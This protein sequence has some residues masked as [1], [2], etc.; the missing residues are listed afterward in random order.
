MADKTNQRKAYKFLIEKEAKG[1]TFTNEEIDAAANWSGDTFKSYR[2]KLLKGLIHK[3]ENG[4]F[5]VKGLLGVTENEFI[6]HLSQTGILRP[7]SRQLHDLLNDTDSYNLTEIINLGNVDI[8]K[9]LLE[10]VLNVDD[11]GKIIE[12]LNV[13]FENAKGS[14]REKLLYSLK[15]QN[16]T[17]TDFDIISGRKEGLELFKKNLWEESKWIE[18]DWQKF[19]ETNTW[20]FGYG[21]DY[22]FL[23]ILQ[24][25]A[26]VSE[27]TVGGEEVV[28]VDFLVGDKNFTTLIE[29]KKPNTPIFDNLK[30]RSG[31]WKLSKD[32]IF[33]VSQILEQKAEWQIKSQS[34]QFDGNREIIKQ[35]TIDPKVI[36]I[37]GHADQFKGENL[38]DEIKSKT[39]E[40]FRRNQRNVDIITF[41]ELYD[42]ANF[43][44]N[45]K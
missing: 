33:A 19:F 15:N 5:Y 23:K 17:K 30:N 29:L 36:L 44:V 7:K 32:L 35:K 31:S 13:V 21:L 27:V 38:D 3:E 14:D 8:F 37:F 41:D 28:I 9:K 12:I 4:S 25:E 26:R 6:E 43:I 11:K 45:Q 16:L 10:I 18:K 20:I 40:L 24:R 22:K 1:S 34:K 42:R 2:Y 39:F